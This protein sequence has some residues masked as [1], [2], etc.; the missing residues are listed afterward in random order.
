M[1]NNEANENPALSKMD[2]S[3]LLSKQVII[4]EID[5]RIERLYEH[6]KKVKGAERKSY[7]DTCTSFI[8]FKLWLSEQ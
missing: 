2:V 7:D 5:K 4:D 1:K 3:G 6:S 8:L